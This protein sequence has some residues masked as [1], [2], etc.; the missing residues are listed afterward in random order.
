MLC[1]CK[2]RSGR[3]YEQ[4]NI[5]ETVKGILTELSGEELIKNTFR[6]QEDLGLD[7]LMMV[8]MLV[9]IEDIFG[10]ELDETDMNPFEL[11]TLQNVID[12]VSKYY[13]DKNE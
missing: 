11:S 4:M 12:M 8:T 1:D 6:L 5:E 7:S 3:G 10:I 9:E 2:K 13:G